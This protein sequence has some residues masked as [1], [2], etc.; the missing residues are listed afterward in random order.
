MSYC[1]FSDGDVYLYYHVG[2]FF[3]CQCCKLAPLVPASTRFL[4][5]ISGAV[6][7]P[8]YKGPIEFKMHGSTKLYTYEE[9]LAHLEDHVAA[10]H[11]VPIYAI[12][13]LMQEVEDLEL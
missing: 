6:D 10:G 8:D 12:E 3:M 4:D 11:K 2:E 1:R 5:T 7:D 9:A 13:T